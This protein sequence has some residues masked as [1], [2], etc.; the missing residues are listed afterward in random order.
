MKFHNITYPDVN[1]G[2]GCRV[3][4][5]I[6]GCNHH[7]KNCQNPETW[8]KESGQEFTQEKED[9]LLNI[10]SKSY[11]KGLTLSGGDPLAYYYNDVLAL[12][13]KIKKDEKFKNKDIWI[14]TGY[15]LEQL[16]NNGRSEILK[17]IDY[18]VDGLYIE[19][20]RD[21]TIPF[22]GSKNQKIYH[23]ISD[24]NNIEYQEVFKLNQNK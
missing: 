21:L 20:E 18:L 10:L 4:L 5:W 1:N 12:C 17:Y 8:D 14:Y 2:A 3:T 23:I 11:I 9:L 15:T 13:E 19:E 7:C 22:R 6:S 16:F 24:L